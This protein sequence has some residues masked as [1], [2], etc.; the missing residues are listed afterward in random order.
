MYVSKDHK[1]VLIAK[2]QTHILC[3]SKNPNSKTSSTDRYYNQANLHLKFMCHDTRHL[4]SI[5]HG[6]EASDFVSFNPDWSPMK[7][8]TLMEEVMAD[9]TLGLHI[10]TPVIS[11]RD[12]V[13]LKSLIQLKEQETNNKQPHEIADQIESNQSNDQTIIE[14]P[15]NPELK[16]RSGRKII[17]PERLTY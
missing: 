10:S 17:A 9:D 5:C 14:F 3:K 7:M 1:S 2:P 4:N 8:S 13:D 11:S 6:S 16:T 15:T 12:N